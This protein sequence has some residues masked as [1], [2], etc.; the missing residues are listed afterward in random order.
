MNL[1]QTF[2]INYIISA[3]NYRNNTLKDN[4]SSI[5]L[6]KK[7]GGIETLS[8][9]GST[10]AQ[11]AIIRNEIP[12]II[13]QFNITSILDAP[14]GDFNWVQHMQ[15]EECNYIGLDIVQEMIHDNSKKFGNQKRK[16]I[17]ANIV[18][19]AET[20]STSRTACAVLSVTD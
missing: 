6:K 9:P 14:C 4:F 17:C 11:T 2:P 19:V 8:G 13:K 3:F 12:K 7:W 20:R 18:A 15:L 5:Y 10:L 1:K 16:F